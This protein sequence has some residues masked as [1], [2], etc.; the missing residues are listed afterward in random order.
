[1]TEDL[2]EYVDESIDNAW[3]FGVWMFERQTDEEWMKGETIED[4]GIGFNSPDAKY[5][6]PMFKH[7]LDYPLKSQRDIHAP[8]FDKWVREHLRPRLLKYTKQF[9]V[10]SAWLDEEVFDHD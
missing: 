10:Y 3:Y 4:N 6:T 9:K 2:Y 7:L 8:Y 5:L 1:M